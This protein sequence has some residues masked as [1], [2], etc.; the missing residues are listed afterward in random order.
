MVA[1]LQ[2]QGIPAHTVTAVHL[3]VVRAALDELAATMETE[4]LIPRRVRT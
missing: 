4:Q 3:S 2:T 1:L